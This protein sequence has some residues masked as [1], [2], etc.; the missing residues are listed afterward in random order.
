MCRVLSSV[1]QLCP[2]FV[3]LWEGPSTPTMANQASLSMGFPRQEYWIGLPFPSLG[4]LPNPG[5]KPLSRESPALV[6]GFFT[7]VPPTI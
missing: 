3:I 7:T 2:V 4:D 5:T 1:T 6:G